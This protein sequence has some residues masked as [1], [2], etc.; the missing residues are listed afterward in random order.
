MAIVADPVASGLVTN[1]ARPGNN[2]TGVSSMVAELSAKRLE[3]L[4]EMIP[5]LTRVAVFWNPDTPFHAKVVEELKTA[6]VSL[7][8]VVNAVAVRS[9]GEIGPAFSAA[10]EAHEQAVYILDSPLAY[11]ERPA[12]LRFAS[13]VRLPAIY[14]WRQFAE[15][16][17]LVSYGVSMQDVMRRTAG[18]VDK[19][20]KGAKPADLPIEQP[21]KF[22]LVVNVKTA[23]ALG[24]T[25]PES[26]LLRAD[27]VIR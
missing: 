9:A 21:T 3:L 25:I 15:D 20:L 18:Y 16:G 1:L 19:I 17:G 11:L 27:E 5:G 24:I 13:R 7:S 10:K 14:S 6:G 4:K 23:K 2:V 22:E 8:I 26:I 12:F